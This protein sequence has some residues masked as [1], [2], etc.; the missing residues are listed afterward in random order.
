MFAKQLHK[1]GNCFDKWDQDN[2]RPHAHT[3]I[4]TFWVESSGREYNK[5]AYVFKIMC[6]KWCVWQQIDENVWSQTRGRLCRALI[7]RDIEEAPPSE[8]KENPWDS[9]GA[10]VGSKHQGMTR[11]P[12]MKTVR[13][14]EEQRKTAALPLSRLLNLTKKDWQP[15]LNQLCSDNQEITVS[16]QQ[17]I[18]EWSSSIL[19]YWCR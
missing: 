9:G 11:W 4:L 7:L 10:Q 19:N 2:G 15:F 13:E 1:K 14:E 8:E 12:G 16:D 17:H 6:R 5:P 18:L 3:H